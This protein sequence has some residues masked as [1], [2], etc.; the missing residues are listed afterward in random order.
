MIRKP[1][2]IALVSTCFF[3]SIGDSPAYAK[4]GELMKSDITSFSSCQ[5]EAL[6]MSMEELSCFTPYSTDIEW[7]Y[8]II[9]GQVYRRLYNLRTQTWIGEWELAP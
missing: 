7:Q 1:M 8:K 2:M 6:L 9:N 3:L 5:S 4:Q